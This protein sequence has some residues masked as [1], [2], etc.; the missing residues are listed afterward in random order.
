[1]IFTI[2]TDIIYRIMFVTMSW[3]TYYDKQFAI[4]TKS[5]NRDFQQ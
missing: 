1:M 2:F 4:C 3:Q 5:S